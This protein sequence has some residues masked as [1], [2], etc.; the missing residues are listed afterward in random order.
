MADNKKL[1]EL[2]IR[3]HF[4]KENILE[5]AISISV[6]SKEE[7]MFGKRGE[8]KELHPD[9]IVLLQEII[10][11]LEKITKDS[12]EKIDEYQERIDDLYLDLYE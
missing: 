12:I 11:K 1:N 10:T 5:D 9:Y 7:V 2:I 3:I 4:P 8:G 6:L